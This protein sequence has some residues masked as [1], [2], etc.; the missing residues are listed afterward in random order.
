MKESVVCIVSTRT[1]EI[2]G[3]VKKKAEKVWKRRKKGF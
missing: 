1:C 2:A 3:G